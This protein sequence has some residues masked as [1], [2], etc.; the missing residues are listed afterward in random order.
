MHKLISLRHAMYVKAYLMRCLLYI[1]KAATLYIGNIIILTDR[2]RDYF[3]FRVVICLLVYSVKMHIVK[4][5]ELHAVNIF[6]MA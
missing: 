2:N 5:Y 4:R 6:S 1:V 3:N